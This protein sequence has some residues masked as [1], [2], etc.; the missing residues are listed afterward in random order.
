MTA[1]TQFNLEEY[2]KFNLPF[3]HRYNTSRA[4]WFPQNQPPFDNSKYLINLVNV[5]HIWMLKK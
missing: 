3:P 4:S 2:H 1:Q 5:C